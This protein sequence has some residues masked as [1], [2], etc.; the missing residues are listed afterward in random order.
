MKNKQ[1]FGLGIG[2]SSVIM[3][4]VVLCLTT[5]AVLAY[6]CGKAD[7]RLTSKK[8]E[9][10]ISY[11]KS[12][13]KAREVLSEVDGVLLELAKNEKSL[14]EFDSL[15]EGEVE[16]LRESDTITYNVKINDS[17]DLFVN[18]QVNEKDGLVNKEKRYAIKQWK[19]VN[20]GYDLS[21][22][23]LDLWD[24]NK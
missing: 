24:P 22:E 16:V 17:I 23:N 3:I 12:D 4:F 1:F 14:D 18:L 19:T 9:Y 7:T 2:L 15:Y 11:Q 6:F 20:K 13:L 10:S 21:D 5:L 8:A